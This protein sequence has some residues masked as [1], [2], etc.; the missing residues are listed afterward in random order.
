MLLQR[1]KRRRRAIAVFLVCGFFIANGLA[2][3]HARAMTHFGAPGATI[4]KPWNMS[5]SQKIHA[6]LFGVT[7]P[8]PSNGFRPEQLAL[9]FDVHQ[10]RTS[11]GVQ[12]E[13]WH[14][15]RDHSRGL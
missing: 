10:F 1:L 11:D 6:L 13:A 3:M 8:R 4:V 15:P 14:I 9:P 7:I 5:L 12:L 2:F